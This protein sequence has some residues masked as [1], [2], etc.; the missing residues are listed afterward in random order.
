MEDLDQETQLPIIYNGRE[1]RMTA[2][3]VRNHQHFKDADHDV[4][5]AQGEARKAAIEAKAKIRT[6]IEKTVGDQA[7]I[8]G[9]TADVTQLNAA[10]ILAKI[11][12]YKDGDTYAKHRQIFMQT[13]EA[14]VPAED[15]E[16]DVYE[17][18]A[19]FL[20]GV[21]SGEIIL[22]ASL[23]GLPVVIGEMAGR[24]TG[25]AQILVAA[26]AAE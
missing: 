18:A 17:Q 22:T 2:A 1:F 23:K 21:Q 6:A 14:L 24:S 15:G 11:V 26:A 4:L 13:I 8:L 16:P 12:A 9:T 25:V 20:A 19:A 3:G 10:A 7:A 5:I